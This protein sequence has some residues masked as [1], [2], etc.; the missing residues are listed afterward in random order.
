MSLRHYT[1]L[2]L[3]LSGLEE[4]NCRANPTQ[5]QHCARFRPLF[6]TIY[7]GGNRLSSIPHWYFGSTWLQS[8]LVVGGV[9]GINEAE[10]PPVAA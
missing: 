8:A 4:A 7:S 6:C 5:S 2:S 3:F 1:T 10:M 9:Y